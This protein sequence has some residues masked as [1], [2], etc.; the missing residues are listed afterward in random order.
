[1]EG[2]G[3]WKVEEKKDEKRGSFRAMFQNPFEKR[4]H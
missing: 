4:A 3:G 1:M 2:G